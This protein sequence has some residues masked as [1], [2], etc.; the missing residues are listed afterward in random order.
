MKPSV[1]VALICSVIAIG[2][3][4]GFYY[5]GNSEFGVRVE[6]FIS[7]FLLL[8]SIAGGVFMFKQSENFLERSFLEDIK[9]ALQGGIMFTILVSGF[10]YIYHTKIDASIIDTKVEAFIANVKK[11][12]PDEKTYFELQLKY[13]ED[14]TW[15]DKT[16]L[17]YMENQEDSARGFISPWSFSIMHTIVGLLLTVFFSIFVTL[18]LRKVV[19]RQ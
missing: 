3:M 8:T 5:S 2:T 9:M 12:V 11:A 6:P 10:V 7:L 13:P 14:K 15:Q 17:D 18:I 4:L 19:L 16:Y 1:K